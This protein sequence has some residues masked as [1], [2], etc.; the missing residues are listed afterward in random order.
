MGRVTTRHRVVR[1]DEHHPGGVG[2]VDTL[3]VEEPLEIRLGPMRYSTTMRTPGHDM[4]LVHGFLASEGVIA[5][6]GDIASARYCTGT[7]TD[8]LTGLP[9]N[10]YN[11]LQIR[12]ADGV[13]PPGTGRQVVTSSACGVCGTDTIEALERASRF[14]LRADQIPVAAAT[15]LSLPDGLRRAQ[16]AFSSTG[17]THAAALFSPAGELLAAREDIGRHNA[18]D[19]VVGWAM[20]NGRRPA[21]GCVLM[22][23]GRIGFELAQKSV[24][25]GIPVL[26][27]I[28]APTALA[29]QTADETGL[30][31]AG[32]VRGERMSIY[33][34]P[35]RVVRV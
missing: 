10:T 26:A 16:R 15:V 21:S 1:I 2:A 29:V 14:D 19:K 13:R 12:L 34:N 32:F 6:P 31:L 25:A 23:S 3:A 8:E 7:V 11:V 4:E 33:S 5:G 24:L 28:S 27:G 9:R 30:T 20:L 17:A 18:V 22:V 35:G